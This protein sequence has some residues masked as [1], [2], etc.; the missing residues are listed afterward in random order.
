MARRLVVIACATAGIFLLA[1][2]GWALLMLAVL[3]E[4]GWPREQPQ[5]AT[6]AVARARIGTRRLVSTVRALPQQM[7]GAT[8]VVAGVAVLPTGAGLVT[9]R[10][11]AALVVLGALLLGLGLVLD[12]TAPERN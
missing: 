2:L 10:V 12:R 9:G 5:W 6:A 4:I 8:A 7:T 11:G 3:V 1:G